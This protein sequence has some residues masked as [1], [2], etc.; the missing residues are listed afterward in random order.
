MLFISSWRTMEARAVE[1]GATHILSLLGIEG[2]PDTPDGMDPARHLHIEVDDVP[3]SFAGD[4]APTFEHV[5]E[6]LDFSTAWDR[7]GPMIVHCYAGVSR[8]TAAALT[9]LCQY[10]PGREMEAAQALRRAAPHAKPNRRIIA[11][12]DRLLGSD[13][14]LV[15]AVDAIG[16]GS[17]EGGGTPLVELSLTL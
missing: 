6:L 7:Q 13:N 15:E 1:L 2:V 14:R 3:A 5:T 17:Y 9:I 12:A 16:Q 11:I 8:S 4:I 10:N